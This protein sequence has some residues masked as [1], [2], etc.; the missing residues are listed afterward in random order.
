MA[1]KKSKI[2]RAAPSAPRS[3]ITRARTLLSAPEDAGSSPTQRI[4][5]LEEANAEQANRIAELETERED[6]N[7]RLAKIEA[8]LAAEG[9]E[10]D[11][12]QVSH[13]RA[14]ADIVAHNMGL[15]LLHDLPAEG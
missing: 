7:T 14:A 9:I 13:V 10:V 11:D 12:A 3:L 1:A 8:T 5:A 2:T 4:A 6:T 15:G